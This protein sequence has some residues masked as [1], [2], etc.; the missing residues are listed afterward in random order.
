VQVEAE[1]TR[2][3]A[4]LESLQARLAA[5]QGS[6][7]LSTIT[8]HLTGSRDADGDGGTS[9]FRDGLAAGWS[10]LLTLGRAVGVTAGALLPFTPLLLLAGLAWRLHVRRTRPATPASA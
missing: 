4:D 8:L 10:A 1:L 2:R 7:D 6:V 3:T 9:G 5:L